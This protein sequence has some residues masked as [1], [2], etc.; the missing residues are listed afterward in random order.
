M[1]TVPITE[2]IHRQLKIK[3]AEGCPYKTIQEFIDAAVSNELHELEVS[4]DE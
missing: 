1:K 4:Q 3:V 2:A